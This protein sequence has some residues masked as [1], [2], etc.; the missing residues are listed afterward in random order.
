M[1]RKIIYTDAPPEIEAAIANGRI[2]P[3]L[4]DINSLVRRDS[5]KP[6]VKPQPRRNSFKTVAAML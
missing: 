3:N 5:T 2:I 4:I 6:L 1:K